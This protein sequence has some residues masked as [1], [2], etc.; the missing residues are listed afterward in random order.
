MYSAKRV[1]NVYIELYRCTKFLPPSESR[2]VY[3]S[4]KEK[5]TRMFNEH[6]DT[7]RDLHDFCWPFRIY[8]S[9]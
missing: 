9:S 1:L 3:T 4:V 8:S 7:H 6:H 2:F 5:G